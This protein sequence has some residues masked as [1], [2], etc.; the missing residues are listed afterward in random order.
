MTVPAASTALAE[1]T[2]FDLPL[3]YS[4]GRV[5]IDQKDPLDVDN[6]FLFSL[7]RREKLKLLVV[8]SGKTNQSLYLRQVYSSSVELSFDMKR[9]F[10]R[11]FVSGRARKP[12][13]YR[14][15]RCPTPDDRI[16]DRMNELRKSGQG[17]IVILGANA[18]LG[19]WNGVTNLP[20]KLTQK[21][22]VDKDRGKYAYSL[23]TYDRNHAIFKSFE[24]SSTLNLEHCAIPRLYR[25]RA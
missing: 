16:R 1:F 21:I 4:K 3:G 18:D 22:Y 8:D 5:R 13:C 11:Q 19:W 17:Q 10:C 15:Q 25:N 14:Y 12:G 2:G 9:D 24:K 7:N 6:E 20:V 23:T